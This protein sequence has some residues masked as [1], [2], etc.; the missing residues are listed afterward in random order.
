MLASPQLHAL[1]LQPLGER[2]AIQLRSRRWGCLR[3]VRVFPL[4]SNPSLAAPPLDAIARLH[5]V[6]VRL[7]K[8]QRPAQLGRPGARKR[9]PSRRSVMLWVARLSG[10]LSAAMVVVVVLSPS[11][12]SFLPAE[13]IR[14][15]QFDGSVR[16]PGQIVG[17]ARGSPFVVPRRSAMPPTAAP[18]WTMAPPPM[19]ATHGSFTS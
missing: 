9:W 8:Q 10:F 11:L 7:S 18:A 14:L 5:N 6:L 2:D 19:S 15:S 4:V 3:A 12:Q 17:G 1:I 13:A 16:F